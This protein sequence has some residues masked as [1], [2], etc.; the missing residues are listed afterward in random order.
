MGFVCSS[1]GKQV[2][3]EENWNEQRARREN[4]VAGQF[5]DKAAGGRARGRALTLDWVQPPPWQ[6]CLSHPS[7][8]LHSQTT[9]K[10]KMAM[11]DSLH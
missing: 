11:R 9:T 3:V 10:S 6:T 2:R 7:S 8:V 4:D 5:A 1:K